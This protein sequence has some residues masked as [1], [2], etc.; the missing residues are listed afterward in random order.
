[1]DLSTTYLGLRLS[2][3]LMPGASPM[4]DDL[5]TV[6]RLEDAGASAIVMH[7]L[8]EE[9]IT[10]EK[11]ATIYHMELYADSYSEALSYFPRSDDFALGPDQ[12]L[13]QI[14]RIKQAVSVPV[15][16]SLNGTTPGGWIEY[17]RQIEQAGA[18][19]LELNTYFVAT[20]PQET[21][22]AVELRILE[23]VRAVCDSVTI[24]VAVK[25][26]PYFSSL[27]NFVYRLDEVGVEG[28]VLF[29]RFYQ[30]D[31]DIDLL[32]AVPTLRLSDSS[33]LLLRLRWLA[34]LSRQISASLAC[35]GGVHTAQDAIKAVMAG[36]DAVQVV[37][38]LLRH[39]PE[40]LKV[41]RDQMIKWMEENSYSS[42]RQMRGS[43]AL[44]RC[45]DPQAFERANYMRTLHSWRAANA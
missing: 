34:I 17:A 30:P 13:E 2:S 33:E 9:Q 18:D 39:G 10:G 41:I 44:N 45:P 37:S 6:R 35:S 26:S 22:W 20:D 36:A 27:S 42:L 16:G 19:A 7:S 3:P 14:Q 25:L 28:L 4:V 40:H 15:I 29:N 23:V 21:G 11:L 43:M 32:E 8:F 12:Y 38:A 24:P 5:D 31:I 1:M